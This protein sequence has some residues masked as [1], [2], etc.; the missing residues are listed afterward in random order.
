MKSL[1]TG[2]A[3][4]IGSHLVDALAGRGD[5]VLVLDDFSSGKRENLAG[6]LQA[7]A[8]V[9]ELDVAGPGAVME[10]F[11][12]FG[13]ESVFHLAAQ[14]DVR[15]SMEDP[16]FDARL[17]VVGT[18]NALEGARRAGASRF[19]FTSTGGAIYGEGAERV[20][21]LPFAETARC[22][23]FSIYGQSKQAAEGFVSLY[24]RTR[25]LRAVTL[26]LG[27]VYG[28]RQDPA[29]EAGVVAIFC[30]AARDGGRPT[31]F[32][33]GEQTRDY[34]HVSD[35]VAALLAAEASEEEGPFN[36]GTGAE[37]TVLE[38]AERVGESFGR[39]D[40]EPAFAPAREG[41]VQRTVLDTA[42]AAERLGWRAE[43]TIATGIEQTVA[44]EG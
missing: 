14:I 36:V 44:A 25:G 16:A 9:T 3:G 22:E 10:A 15:R 39:D 8:Q 40:F 38:L 5:E 12:A 1:V 29:T 33:D 11:E 18:V 26:R 6:A 30:G 28:P 41:E 17:N 23:P 42:A 20:D 4:F 43:Y 32:G 24:A 21:E 7:G 34:V 35:V 19:V 2:G 31:V 37:T 13:P 27:N